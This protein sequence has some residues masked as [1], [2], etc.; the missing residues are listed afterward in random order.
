VVF[1]IGTGAEL[2]N[3]AILNSIP[4]AKAG[5]LLI[6]DDAD[7][8]NSFSAN[9]VLSIP[10]TLERFVPLVKKALSL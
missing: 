3:D 8:A 7:L 1:S 9:T 10:Y 5:Q 2:R 6:I 4:S